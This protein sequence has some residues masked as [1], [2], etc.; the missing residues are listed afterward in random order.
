VRRAPSFLPWARSAAE[1]RDTAGAVSRDNTPW[2]D[3]AKQPATLSLLATGPAAR[4]F[5]PP[6]DPALCWHQVSEVEPI[7]LH[8][9]A[10]GRG[11]TV[12]KHRP[13]EDAGV[14]LAVLAARVDAFR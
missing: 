14:E 12:S 10:H 7:P 13:G 2:T 3:G 4:R 9:P 1:M 6:D 11:H 8:D 5:W